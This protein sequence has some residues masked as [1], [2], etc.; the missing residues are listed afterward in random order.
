MIQ[1]PFLA[2]TGTRHVYDAHTDMQ[3]EY[4]HTESKGLGDK[5]FTVLSGEGDL[6]TVVSRGLRNG[7]LES[8]ARRHTSSC[9]GPP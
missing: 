8:R 5:H 2:S 9:F 3:A 4:L 1:N 6:L 7:S